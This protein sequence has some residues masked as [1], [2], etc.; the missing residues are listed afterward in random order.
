MIIPR[1]IEAPHGVPV[2][3]YHASPN[4]RFHCPQAFWLPLVRAIEAL[5]R[6]VQIG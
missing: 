1:T 6:S 4:V 3:I 2:V 5:A